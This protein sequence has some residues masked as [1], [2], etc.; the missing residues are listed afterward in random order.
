MTQVLGAPQAATQDWREREKVRARIVESLD[1][2]TLAVLGAKD[3]G[4]FSSVVMPEAFNLPASDFHRYLTKIISENQMSARRECVIGPRGWGKSTTITEGGTL[5]VVARNAYLPMSN[6]YKFILIVSDTTPQACARLAV[7]KANLETNDKIEELYPE[8]HGKGPV[9]RSDM[10]VTRNGVCIAA[11]GMESSI[12]GTRYENR[13]PDLILLDDPDNLDTANS[14]TLSRDREERF[15][16]DLLKCGHAKTDVFVVGTVL[17]R[18]C[19]VHKIMH[20][21]DFSIWNVRLFKALKSFPTRMDLWNRWGEIIKDRTIEKRAATA[22]AFYKSNKAEMDLGGES[23]WPEVHSV[24]ALMRE[25]YTEGR[26]A[27]ITEKQ[28][29]LVEAGTSHFLLEKYRMIGDSEFEDMMRLNPIMTLYVD[30]SGGNSAASKRMFLSRGADKFAATIVGKLGPQSYLFVTQVAKQC[31]QSA[32]FEEIAKLL[33]TYR[34]FRLVVEN[35]AGQ[36]H[37][38]EALRKFLIDRYADV[39]W[40]ARAAENGGTVA[41]ILPRGVNNSVAKEE[42]IS[43]LEPHLDNFTLMLRESMFADFKDLVDEFENWPNSE[44]DDCLDS[45]SGAFFSAYKTFQLRY[46]HH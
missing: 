31:R 33:Q 36:I 41:L 12:R 24:Y 26:K 8:I 6:R 18:N 9:W 30:P 29:Q 16:R 3:F 34:V 17:S 45:L 44:F 11:A 13:R 32:Q 35:N 27:F 20:S 10:I 19:I 40:V 4:V 1:S 46:L 2:R 38:V 14:P 39:D 5:W 23:N 42:R 28:N 25:Y 7:I 15:T 21:E 22:L 37:Y 43:M